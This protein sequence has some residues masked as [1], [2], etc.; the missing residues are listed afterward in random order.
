MLEPRGAAELETSGYELIDDVELDVDQG[1]DPTSRTAQVDR[2]GDSHAQKGIS[3]SIADHDT[4]GSM[5]Q[6]PL[7]S[8]EWSLARNTP[9]PASCSGSSTSSSAARKMASL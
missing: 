3:E 1:P 5:S 4:T 8:S 7:A 9:G 2:S 6:M